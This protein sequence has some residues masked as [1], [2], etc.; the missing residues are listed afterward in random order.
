MALLDFHT[1]RATG[2]SFPALPLVVVTSDFLPKAFLYVP[3]FRAGDAQL[4][5]QK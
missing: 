1:L 3:P 5:Q 2:M 4:V